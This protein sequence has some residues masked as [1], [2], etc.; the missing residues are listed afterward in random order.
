MRFL[1][2][3]FAFPLLPTLLSGS[4][5]HRI[6]GKRLLMRKLLV[7]IGLFLGAL[8]VSFAGAN[9]AAP[10][11]LGRTTPQTMPRYF[12][13]NRGQWPAGQAFRAYGYSFG[14]SLGKDGLMLRLANPDDLKPL[15]RLSSRAIPF[16][17]PEPV[18]MRELSLRFEGAS[19]AARL[20][21][22]DEL[23]ARG[24]WFQG[25][26][27]EWRSGIPLYEQVRDGQ[28]YP[29]I[30]ATFYGREGQL[31]YDLDVA[32][33]A[34]T[35]A[36]IFD[37]DGADRATIGKNGDLTIEV[38]GQQ[39]V[40][41]KPLAWQPDGQIRKPV[42]VS[43][44]LLP[45]DGRQG[46]R[47]GLAMKGYDASK[48]L[49][50]DPVLTFATYLSSA[51]SSLPD[52]YVIDLAIDT[53]NNVYVLSTDSSEQS[54]TVQKL[55]SA[56]ALVYTTTFSSAGG[57]LFPSALRV[58]ATGQAYIASSVTGGFPTTSTGYQP[59]YPNHSYGGNYNAALS[60]LS[61]DGSSL[62]YST[63]FGGTANGDYG[64][65]YGNA[66]AL[67]NLGN[68]Y[69]AGQAGGENFPTTAGAY[70]T[71]YTNGNPAAFVAKFNPSAS[72][73]ASLVYS[74]LAGG[75]YTDVTGVAVDST[76]DAY[77]SVYSVY[78]TAPVTS[79][80]FVYSGTQTSYYCAN[81]TSVN[82]TG[83][84]LVYSAYLGPATPT[85]VAVDGSQDVYVAGW[86]IIADD[87]PTTSG[88][89]QT[90]YPDG[91]ALE[92]NPAGGL[93]YSTFLSG[94]SGGSEAN[95][96]HP[97]SIA[98][99]P[100]CTSACT[101]FIAGLTDAGD[102]PVIN[103]LSGPPPAVTP[104]Y[105]E[106][107]LV[108]LNGTGSATLTSGYISGLSSFD[109]GSSYGPD[110]N[111]GYAPR[112]AVDSNGNAWLAGDTTGYAVPDFPVTTTAAP[113]TTGA[114][115]AEVSMSNSG[116]VI[117]VPNSLNFGTSIPVDVSSTLYDAS[118]GSAPTTI[119]LR[120]M[121]SA[122]V[123]LTSIVADPSYFTE[124]DNCNGQIAASSYCTATIVFTPGT[125]A[126]VTGTLTITSDGL[127]SPLVIPLSGQ[128]A[129]SGFLVASPNTLT[130]GNVTVNTSSAAQTVTLTNLGDDPVTGLGS[131]NIS[132]ADGFN[133]I[134]NCPSSLPPGDS[135]QDQVTFAPN[136]SEVGP[137]SASL[138]NNGTYP[139][140]LYGTGVLP[141][142]SGGSQSIAFSATTLNFGTEAVGVASGAQYVYL[143]NTGS[144]PL[145]FLTPAVTITS[146]QGAASDFQVSTFPTN[147][148]PQ[149]ETYAYVTFTPS[150][151]ATETATLTFPVA[152]SSTVYSVS[153]VG[154]GM[155]DTQT[156][157]F[158]PGNW[159]F[160]D[161]PVG[162]TSS[163][164]TFY[165]FNAGDTPFLVD[166]VLGSG[167]FSVI[168]TS[169]PGRS[170]PAGTAPGA[171]TSASCSINVVF[172]PTQTGP[173]TGTLTVIDAASATPQ[174]IP[175]AANG[176]T[177][178]GVFTATPTQLDYGAIVEGTSS[179]EQYVTLSNSG[180][181]NINFTGASTTGDYAITTNNCGLPF[182]IGPSSSQCEIGV[183]FTPT[184]TTS[185]DNGTL[186]L[187][188][189]AGTQTITLTGGGEAATLASGLSPTSVNFGSYPVNQDTNSIP[190][191]VRNSGTETL[192]FNTAATVTGDFVIASDQCNTG[193]SGTLAPG[194]DCP[195]YVYFAPAASGTLSGT[196]KVKSSA[197][198][199]TA[200][201][202]GTG[203]AVS[204]TPSYFAPAEVSFD[205]QAL[206]SI[207]TP[208]TVN[209]NY[210]GSS[211]TF[212]LTGASITAG[213]ANFQ[214]ASGTNALNSCSSSPG[215]QITN[216][217][218]N[219]VFSPS[220][221][222][223]ETGTLTI[224]SSAGSFAVILSGYAPPV[225]DSGYLTPSALSFPTQVLTTTSSSPQLIY[226]YNTGAS[227]MTVGTVGGTNVGPTSEFQIYYDGCSGQS[228]A[229]AD[230]QQAGGGSCY[231]Y[232]QFA[233]SGTGTRT[234]ALTIPVTYSDNTT[235]TFTAGLTGIGAAQYNEAVLSPTI[236]TFP[237]TAIGSVNTSYPGYIYLTNSG[238]L[239]FHVGQLTSTDV[240]IGSTV[241]GDFTAASPYGVDNCSNSTV[242][243]GSYCYLYAYF[244]PQSAGAKTGAITFPVTYA[245]ATAP[246]TFTATLTGNGIA[247]N[248]P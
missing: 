245:N 163:V 166:R 180:D 142:G 171:V 65:D 157:E 121:G 211:T 160:P 51:T 221:P 140:A 240:V 193:G 108:A 113:T 107:F 43:Y 236:V 228:V 90:S 149:S 15:G 62:A 241:T 44:V 227:A 25:G 210:G 71:S 164:Q 194:Q 122:P 231:V 11:A 63:Y 176:I 46:R 234:G 53:S 179:A 73:A 133:G 55:T 89:Y 109:N 206:N 14:V 165:V 128:G 66:L 56:G 24:A 173:R 28:V 81:V 97:V 104:G 129:D 244:D 21:G 111:V 222:G 239:P 189:S 223:Y 203:V 186:L 136:E 61:A 161:Q 26:Q 218:I 114:W 167:D 39:F 77:L 145:N 158:Q 34:K 209:F 38:D 169:C 3:S 7:C 112:V 139:V 40:L 54:M 80:A 32:P 153:L 217:Q 103:G 159:I 185:P 172:T 243:A 137:Q 174:T 93:V 16:V 86:D 235:G 212:A 224:T 124:S 59:T 197:G 102:F 58:N 10:V 37:L 220:V 170:L 78:C 6:Q 50:I 199:L 84:G 45:P 18:P 60:V 135:C 2:L 200:S 229:A 101:A 69:L 232:V 67:D 202:A 106:G 125:D 49:T 87:F 20:T 119:A 141:S 36:L 110:S 12:E 215:S 155:A 225:S 126:P 79:G 230:S 8:G 190:I 99:S 213:S 115:L 198:T 31:E 216:C 70:Q 76:G 233:P 187:T 27:T 120:N 17:A 154:Q 134:T 52:Y 219:I 95:Y 138:Y 13:A 127:N 132:A 9:P 131:V 150:V 118:L 83:T 64:A 162:T 5:F 68:A 208:I 29:G 178:A 238:N 214:L 196:F 205:E 248:P 19:P 184:V 33:G 91:F 42:E 168:S 156:L 30:D 47:I 98:L 130:F 100:G 146:S 72:G 246:V 195:I 48:P 181:I 96:V 75:T 123:T 143:T 226:L 74:T 117:A 41:H 23:S 4:S 82:P 242:A 204:T 183:T 177:A 35:G 191:Y 175:L 192:T 152:G 207:S 144:Q 85:A 88:A 247:D 201:L 22:L 105:W 92:L 1:R 237:D 151:A 188:T 57:S 182:T 94:P 148:E 147:V 116:N